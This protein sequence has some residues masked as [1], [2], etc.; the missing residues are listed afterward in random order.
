MI[1]SRRMTNDILRCCATCKHLKAGWD[2]TMYCGIDCEEL[3]DP[4]VMTMTVCKKYKE[5]EAN[6]GIQSG[7]ETE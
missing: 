1:R 4:E 7:P 5:V 6:A 2:K 3:P